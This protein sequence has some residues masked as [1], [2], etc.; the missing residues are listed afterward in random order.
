[1]SR[2]IVFLTGTRADFGK[3]QPLAEAMRRCDYHV[4]LYVT[5]MHMLQRFGLTKSE[6]HRFGAKWDIDVN[7]HVNQHPGDGQDIVLTKTITGF[8]DFLVEHRPDLVVIH[9]DRVEALAASLTCA[10]N[11]V[12]CAHIEGGEISGSIDEM[13]RHCNSKLATFHF[14]SSEAARRRVLQ[15]GEASDAVFAIGSPELD[16]HAKPSG[17]SLDEV[18]KHYE[19][20]WKDY[21]VV[22]FHPVTSE[23][24]TLRGQAEALFGSLERSGRR[25]VVIL[26]NNDPGSHDIME[27]IGDLPR[28]LF[29][30]IPSMRFNYFS[31]L[32]KNAAVLVGNS[33]AGVREAPFLGVPSLD[34]GTRQSK[35]GNACS[36]TVCAA[37][38]DGTIQRFL[39]C[40]WQQR[41]PRCE[42]FGN[43]H[44]VT[45]FVAAVNTPAFWSRSLQKSFTN[46][47]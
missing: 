1:M 4:K 33:S 8:S 36:V 40:H 47:T 5:G 28:K 2:V 26:P 42:D 38:D 46:P 17:V 27:V 19:V 35:R 6:V 15:M 30:I 25:F 32:L 16:V 18:R 11:N 7:E 41:F 24:D 3:I 45:R 34:I 37:Y 44:A 21:G 14:V 22:I 23:T 29:R 39:A 20:P 12:R 13:F 9:G 31:E 10:I 43:G